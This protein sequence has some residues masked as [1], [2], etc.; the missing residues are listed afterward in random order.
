MKRKKIPEPPL[1]A[2]RFLSWYCRPELL[3][4]LQGDLNEYFERHLKSKGA[5][6]AKFIYVLDVFKFFRSYTIRKPEFLNLLIHWLMLSSYIKTSGRSIVRNKLFSFINIV[7]LAISMSV[8]LLMIALLT[9]MFAYDKFHEKGDRIYRVISHYQYLDHAD[10]NAYASTSLKAGKDIEESVTGIEDA[11][12][13]YRGFESD[14]KGGDKAVPLTGFWS[15]KSL[16]NVFSFPMLQGNP[17]NAL[18]EPF[19]IVLTETAAKKIFNSVDALGKTVTLFKDQQ[20]TVT[21]IIQDVPRFSHVKFDMLGSLS[22]R[23]ITE[24]DNKHE[25]AWDN[26][27]NGYVYLL[28]P[29]K[30]DLENLQ[31]NLDELS[32]KNN[33]TVKNS[34]ITLALQPL[35]K[36][37][38][39]DDMNNSIGSVMGSSDV[40]MIGILS[41]IVI[42]SACFN[43]TN[44]SIARSLRRSRE[45]GIRKVVGALKGHVLGQFIVEAVIISLLALALSFALF[46]FLRPFFLSIQPKL[47]EMLVLNLSPSLVLYFVLLAIGVGIA[48]GFLPALF[49]ARINAI[50]VL[51]DS[52]TLRVFKN[53]TTRKVLIVAQYT[54]SIIFIGATIIGYKQYKFLLNFDL[55]YKTENILNINL[56]GNKAKLVAKEL[57]LLPEVQGMAQSVIITSIGNYWGTQMKYT[58]PTDSTSVYYNSVDENYLPL[59]GIQLIAGKN[60]TPKAENAEET[61]VIIN[62]EVMKRFKIGN[63]DPLRAIDEIVTVD[64]KKMKVIGVIKN[65]HYGKA[66]SESSEVMLRYLNKD[67]NFINAKIISSDILGTMAK[68]ESIWKK[69]DDVH[70]LQAE[71]YTERIE[72]SY[73]E[74][75]ASLKVIGFLSFLAICIASLGLL[76]MVVFTTETKLKE[77]SIRKVLGASERN[78]IY[79]LSKG[80]LLLL[81]VASCISLPVTYLFFEKIALPEMTNHAPIAILDLLIG[82]ITILVIA[83]LLIGS[84]TLKVART[85]PATVLKNE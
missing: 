60:F 40:W 11:A 36:I 54:I 63:S 78:L 14:V 84:Q 17:S 59:H 85:N 2:Q 56:Q 18:Q 3:E 79:L 53:V 31:H 24:K 52:S 32:A 70:P 22:T 82:V 16:F 10:N 39:G 50:Q 20:Y 37:A 68:I 57:A 67:A 33:K 19:S 46:I 80:F 48:A 75:S 41:F 43:Y 29:E 83:L 1:W 35:S 26:M 65:F 45:V 69:I 44:L 25:M 72:K 66:D 7:G 62:E 71:F 21:G 47:Q 5:R 23:A 49:F 30:A 28:L 73:R 74:L 9:D 42:L 51:K 77:I 58:D 64:N 4:D 27:W 12:I 55:G 13:L 6:K 38:L 61:E 76:G 81:L 34:K 15:D 8:G